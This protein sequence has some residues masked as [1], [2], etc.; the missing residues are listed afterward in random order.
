MCHISWCQLSA[1]NN[2]DKRET[3]PTS[4]TKARDLSSFNSHSCLQSCTDTSLEAIPAFPA[5]PLDLAKGFLLVSW[6]LDDRRCR[7]WSYVTYVYSSQASTDLFYR[8]ASSQITAKYSG[9]LLPTGLT[10]DKLRRSA[11]KSQKASREI[12]TIISLSLQQYPKFYT[13]WNPWN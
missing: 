11:L 5:I 13:P 6:M 2:T 1:T 3:S 9:K 12:T 7:D 10:S 8:K 4:S